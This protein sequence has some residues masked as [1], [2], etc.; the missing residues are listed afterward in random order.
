MTSMRNITRAIWLHW[1]NQIAYD[2]GLISRDNYLRM[3][4]AINT[5]Y[6]CNATGYSTAPVRPTKRI[7][8]KD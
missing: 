5:K 6:H 7:A 1:Y 8:D 2:S 4:V 3:Q